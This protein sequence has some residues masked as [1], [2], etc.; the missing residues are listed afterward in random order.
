V[1]EQW[2]EQWQ[3]LDRGP[4]LRLADAL[5][6]GVRPVAPGRRPGIVLCTHSVGGPLAAESL[7]CLVD[8]VVRVLADQGCRPLLTVS[9]PRQPR[10]PHWDLGAQYSVLE[11]LHREYLDRGS[12]DRDSLDQ[13][14]RE[15]A[16][17]MLNDGTATC[18]D[19][20]IVL[21]PRAAPRGGRLLAWE[22][23]IDTTRVG[24]VLL[25]RDGRPTEEMRCATHALL[26]S[27]GP[28]DLLVG[29]S[30]GKRHHDA[31]LSVLQAASGVWPYARHVWH[32][33]DLVPAG[34]R[35]QVDRDVLRLALLTR[36]HGTWR[37]E[38]GQLD[39][40]A[41]R[42]RRWRAACRLTTGPR[43]AGTLARLRA[44]ITDNVS[45]VGAIREIDAWSDAALSGA[46]SDPAAPRAVAAALQQLIGLDS[47]I[48]EA[49]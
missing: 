35:P 8:V 15:Q 30:A 41:R 47:V 16:I 42:L 22:D 36:S 45:M 24:E 11:S 2:H 5:S 13:E 29:G 44:Q 48:D 31:C 26:S 43:S 32:I 10:G 4:E 17:R 23:S 18:T 34:P 33:G 7:G 37:W 39:A 40:A 25:L 12:L 3:W 9:Q 19:G 1:S 27:P 6:A 38:D 49:A 20:Y 14:S 46:G 28:L 21:D